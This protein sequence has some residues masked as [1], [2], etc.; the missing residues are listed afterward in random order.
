MHN[1]IFEMID[2]IIFCLYQVFLSD[3]YR[4]FFIQLLFKADMNIV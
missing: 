2:N 3:I 4:F 1:N